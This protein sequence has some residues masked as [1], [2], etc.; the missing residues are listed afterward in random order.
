M[1]FELVLTIAAETEEECVVMALAWARREMGDN[2]LYRSL[3]VTGQCKAVLTEHFT[4]DGCDQ[5]ITGAFWKHNHEGKKLRFHWR[6]RN[7][8]KLRYPDLPAK[9]GKEKRS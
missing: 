7:K 9:S 3:A 8:V 4:C 1:S 2:P 5:P 6:C